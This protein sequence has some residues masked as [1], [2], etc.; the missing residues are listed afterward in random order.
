MVFS[1]CHHLEKHHFSVFSS[2]VVFENLL[3]AKNNSEEK[4]KASF[5][6]EFFFLCREM[7]SI[8]LRKGQSLKPVPGGGEMAQKLSVLVTFT[9]NPSPVPALTL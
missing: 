2:Q 3:S 4:S 8:N 1:N 9:E 6:I 5:P 7:C